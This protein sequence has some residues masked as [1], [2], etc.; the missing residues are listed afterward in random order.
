MHYVH[1]IKP[2]KAPSL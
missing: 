1:A 2:K